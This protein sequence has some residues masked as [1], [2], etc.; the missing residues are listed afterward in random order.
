MPELPDVEVFK[1]YLDSTALHKKVKKATAPD[2]G[3]LA[4]ISP[5]GFA[6]KLNGR[7][8]RRSHRHG[9]HLFV[10][11]G[12]GE[13]LMMHFGMT[14]YFEYFKNGEAP[15][16][17]KGIFELANGHTLAYI[18]KRKLGKLRLISD[19][20]EYVREKK[21]G[22][23]ALDDQLSFPNFRDRLGERSVGIK[24]ALMDQS[25]VA[26]I[27]NV[28]SDEILYQAGVDPRAE[29]GKLSEK[30][31]RKVYRTMRKVLKATIDRGADPE[32]FPRSW[33]TPRRE[34]GAECPKCGGKIKKAR[35]GGRSCYWCPEH[36]TEGT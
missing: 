35:V 2:K 19:L 14:G 10:D 29:T 30:T 33:L 6:Q 23:D 4:G 13:W 28:Y 32:Q 16:Y 36:Q 3:V 7:T 27:G 11:I 34:A 5:R 25:K 1:R 26:G 17:A 21:L 9:K 8:F 24:A 18:N 22:P 31:L 12:K 20:D 15:E